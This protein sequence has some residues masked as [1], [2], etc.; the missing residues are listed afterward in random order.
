MKKLITLVLTI[1]FL[2][3][4]STLVAKIYLVELGTVGATTWRT[5]GVG[6]TLVNL[7]ST[8][9]GGT[10]VSLN[11]WLTD[12]CLKVPVFSGDTL[13]SS[14]QVWI[15]KGTYTLTG[16][17]N[18]NKAIKVYGGF[19]GTET[20]IAA[21]AKGTNAWDFTNATILDG[22]S[23]ITQ[24]ILNVSVDG[25]TVQNFKGA[26]VSPTPGY[27]GGT[28]AYIAAGYVMQN[29]IVTGNTYTST[30][31]QGAGGVRV[32]GG[33]LLNC[34]ILNNTS[35]AGGGGVAFQSTSEI[36]GC[37]IENNTTTG[38]AAGGGLMTSNT[39]GGSILNCIIKG[40][41]S[42]SAGGGFSSYY[43]TLQ[44][45]V[46]ISNTQFI[47]NSAGTSGGAIN[48][49]MNTTTPINISGCTFTGN[50]SNVASS[51]TAGGG[52]IFAGSGLM[53]INKCTFTNNY[54]TASN[55]GAILNN[56]ATT[57]ISN[58]I[59]SGN[60]SPVA[61]G[62]LYTVK[63]ATINNCVVSGNY[64]TSAIYV[65]P[66]IIG[67]F[68]N[69]T[70]AS[71]TK[72][73]GT[74]AS[75]YLGVATTVSTFTNCL[76]Y[77]CGTSPIGYGTGLAPTAT[78]CGFGSDIL[79]LPTY[80]GNGCINTIDATSFKDITIDWKLSET[81]TAKD[82]G[83]DLTAS[84]ITTDILGTIRPEGSAYDM[85]AYEYSTSA[86]VHSTFQN[87]IGFT[88][89]KNAIVSKFDGAIQVFSINGKVL[90][91]T[92]VS[93]GQEIN[94]GSGVYIVRLSTYEGVI[95]QKIIL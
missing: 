75:I 6:D 66:G 65:Y 41:T 83:T 20:T 71:N 43:S 51:S 39:G 89:I 47:E 15:A 59:F 18:A 13:K 56:T 87:V 21:R 14:D 95:V 11:A 77:N 25:F 44:P 63:S 35:A 16:T 70:V 94:L 24:G 2:C 86:A 81:S 50:S 34:H 93:V 64:G 29:C 61:G 10:S 52:A 57:T 78:F 88:V 36:N 74:A 33:K 37:L 53:T 48:V 19:A 30:G 91:T 26:N 62:A 55:G 4:S 8:G 31:T 79:A 40:N 84:G 46:T 80:A 58:T 23:T 76:F 92:H 49:A 42:A 22:A 90:N 38:T 67:T 27:G 5:A 69:V 32:T 1:A 72:A 54:A 7:S 73:D 68:N 60:S 3:N 17:L 28:G 12:K 82:A 85:G 45:A 9:I